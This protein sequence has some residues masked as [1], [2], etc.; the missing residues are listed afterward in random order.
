MPYCP[1]PYLKCLLIPYFLVKLERVMMFSAETLSAAGTKWSSVTHTLSGF[2]IRSS[3]IPFFSHSLKTLITPGPETS[4]IM[5]LS[6]LAKT[7]SPG[8]SLCLPAARASIFSVIVIPAKTIH[9]VRDIARMT[10]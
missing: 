9:V 4:C 5:T 1:R 10:D 6:T 7:T 2:Q 3:F 8:D